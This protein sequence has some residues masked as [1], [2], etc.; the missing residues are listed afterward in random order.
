[1]CGDFNDT[2]SSYTYTTISKNLKDAFVE[3]GTGF[4]RT[5]VGKFP[6]YRIDYIL[7]QGELNAYDFQTLPDELSDHYP[8]T[9]FFELKK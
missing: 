3:T 4:G 2:P 9:A 8:I 5:Y 7:Y 6:S 1:M